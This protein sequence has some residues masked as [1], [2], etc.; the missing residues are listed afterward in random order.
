MSTSKRRG[1][2]PL[3]KVERERFPDRNLHR[4]GR[5]FYFFDLDDNVMFLPTPI[6]MFEKTTRREASLS[7]GHFARI[8]HLIGKPGLYERYVV[9]L[10]DET[11]SFRRFRDPRH[12]RSPLLD[13]IDVALAGLD[14]TWKGP[15]WDFFEHA[16]HNE[17]PV[18]IITARGHHPSTIEAGLARLH[19]AQHLSRPPTYL[20]VYPVSHPETRAQL[21]DGAL[22]MSV[23]ARK[24]AAVLHAVG[25][26]MRRYGVSDHH[27]FGISDDSPENL[28]LALRALR[29]LKQRYPNNAFFAFDAS[30]DPIVR[31]EVGQR[32]EHEETTTRAQQLALFA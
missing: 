29:E 21:G 26:A 3:P 15:S 5:S 1:Q 16:V 18:A 12:G 13:D 27:R 9:D 24:H 4:G 22:T 28:A 10:D 8:S 23:A 32:G 30:Q 2:L 7:T 6:F 17:R 11:G 19:E 14:V 31:I 20:G 25:E